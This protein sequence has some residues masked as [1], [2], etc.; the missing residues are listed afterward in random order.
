MGIVR[1]WYLL[2]FNCNVYGG[3]NFWI[4]VVRNGECEVIVICYLSVRCVGK[5]VI[6]I[7]FCII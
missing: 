5:V 2:S 3:C 6:S 4:Y 1:E 7:N